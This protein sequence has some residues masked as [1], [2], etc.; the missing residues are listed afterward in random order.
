MKDKIIRVGIFLICM[1]VVYQFG[2]KPIFKNDSSKVVTKENTKANSKWAEKNLVIEKDKY[3]V[4]VL[5]EE[6]E[7]IV[8]SVSA[9]RSGAKT[10][11]LAQGNDIGGSVCKN[12]QFDFEPSVGPNGEVLN[13]GIFF[14]MSQALGK[15]VSSEKYIQEM[16]KL[17]KREKNLEVVY[18]VN[19][20]SPSID[21]NKLY[22]IEIG[23]NGK[24][25]IYFGKRFIDATKDGMLL[26]MCKVPYFVGG[27][28]I[29]IKNNYQPVFLNFEVSGVKWSDVDELYNKSNA[30]RLSS[31][32]KQYKPTQANFRLGRIIFT[33][34]GDNKVIVRG[35][36]CF[37]IRVDDKKSLESEYISAVEETRNFAAFLRDRFI[38]FQN[39]TYEKPASEFFIKTHR[40]FSSIH[41]LSVNE[42][43]ENTDFIDKISIGANPV[44]LYINNDSYTRYVIGKPL[45]YSIP[46]GCIIPNKIDNLLMVGS[47]VGY[48]SLAAS[49]AVSSGINVDVGQA[50]GIAAVFSIVNDCSPIDI[51]DGKDKDY[52]L[53]LEDILKSVGMN[54]PQFKIP[55]PIK[56]NWV[57]PSIKELNSLGLIS[58]GLTNDYKLNEEA[59]QEDFAV[60][61][62][63]GVVRLAPEKY[64]LD[65]DRRLRKYFANKGLTK[66]GAAQ[67]LLAMNGVSSDSTVAYFKACDKGYINKA[68]MLRLKDKKILTMDQVFELSTHNIKKFTGKSFAE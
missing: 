59:S 9:A 11:L 66:D 10:L 1:L 42:V 53:E 49:S 40:H 18:G 34:E 47:K 33:N 67:I 14:E 58:S 16:D 25:E 22:G 44:E 46:L 51:I 24:K 63:N 2:I 54:L 38:A 57:Y 28:D 21:G 15:V 48:S 35:V 62:L 12:M 5:G 55:N 39:S 27:E 56:D 37:N 6:P 68:M 3:D 36:E 26:E 29:N 43:L 8:A 13:K 65:L 19:I 41:I 31:I 60:L 30:N 50:A 20:I 45:Q 64:S 7:G 23:V 17:I 4:I 61:L 32:L 52:I